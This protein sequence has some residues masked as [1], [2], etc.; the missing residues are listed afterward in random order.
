MLCLIKAWPG[1]DFYKTGPR[2]PAR[3]PHKQSSLRQTI[4]KATWYSPRFTQ[5]LA[6]S[7]RQRRNG[8]VQLCS[9]RQTPC[10]IIICIEPIRSS[11]IRKKPSALSGNIIH[12]SQSTGTDGGF[13]DGL[14]RRAVI[15]Q[16]FVKGLRLLVLQPDDGSPDIQ[17][18][19]PLSLSP[20]QPGTPFDLPGATLHL[21]ISRAC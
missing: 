19:M 15:F 21:G 16:A 12:S 9:T 17:G 18:R 3:L 5:R 1:C 20:P 14:R 2:T 11:E 6:R 4:P 7:L 8:S 13:R 10:R